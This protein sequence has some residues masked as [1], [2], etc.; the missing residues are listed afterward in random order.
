MSKSIIIMK[1]TTAFLLGLIISLVAISQAPVV[2]W[3]RVLGSGGINI[4][5]FTVK[6]I[7]NG[8]ISVWIS[9]IMGSQGMTV[10]KMTADG[11]IQWQTTYTTQYGVDPPVAYFY[12][13]DGSIV[14]LGRGNK[15]I[16]SDIYD[17]YVV[18]LDNNGNKLWENWY[19]GTQKD[20]PSSI[21]KSINGGYLIIGSTISPELTGDA[22]GN[23]DAWLIKISEAGVLEWQNDLGGTGTEGISKNYGRGKVAESSDGSIYVLTQTTSI[24]GDVTDNHG[25]QDIWLVKLN[26]GGTILWAKSLGGIGS[27]KFADL[28]ISP[29][30]ELYVLGSSTSP[31]LTIDGTAQ[32]DIYV[33][34]VSPAGIILFQKTFGS[35]ATD[36]ATQIASIGNDGSC[37]LLG[38]A[39]SATGDVQSVTGSTDI[40]IFKINQAGTILW[41]NSIDGHYIYHVDEGIFERTITGGVIQSSDGGYFMSGMSTSTTIPGYRGFQDVLVAKVSSSGVL[42]WARA[43]GGTG[44][45]I[46]K[47]L[48][49]ELS[50]NEFVVTAST[51]SNDGDVQRS[52]GGQCPW[53]IKTGPLNTIKGTLFLDRN[54]DGIKD[55]GEPPFSLAKVN[56]SKGS[57]TWTAVPFDGSFYLTADTGNYVTAPGIDLLYYTTVPL[58]H[59]SNFSTYFNTDSFSF[60]VQPI[61]GMQD[62]VLN[63]IPLTPA[64]PGFKADYE[65]TYRNV[66]TVAI[67]SAEV[68]FKMDPRSTLFSAIPSITS[69]IGDTLKW[70]VGAL[71]PGALGKITIKLQLAA[72][73]ALNNGDTLT[74]LALITP[75]MG[76]VT[77]NDDSAII[78]QIVQGSFDPND[79]AENHGGRI[80]P[81]QIAAGEYLTY[82]IRFQNLGT[83]LAFN[84]VVRDTLDNKLDW[85]TF[86]M[87]SA[88][89]PYHL[90]INESNKLVW[91]FN[92]IE[93]PYSAINEP[94][95]HGYIAFRIKPKAGLGIGANITNGASIYFDFNLPVETNIV[96]TIVG[97]P[98]TLPLHLV[99]FS[100]SYRKPDALL[101]WSTADEFNVQ[102]FII[103]R[104]TDPL[105]FAAVGTVA[106]KGGN[107]LT[108]Y[109]FNDKLASI[110]GDKFYYRLKMMDQDSKFTYS[111]IQFVQREGRAINELV[112]SPNPI[113]GRYGFAWINLQKETMA[114]IGVVDMNGNYRSLGQQRIKKGFNVVPLD[115]FGL[116]AGAYF[117]QVKTGQERLISR[118]VLVQ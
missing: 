105:H 33:A 43:Y 82:L 52:I 12:N 39:G 30:G 68:L 70:N 37:V 42:E 98:I 27:D 20:V 111:N 18:K 14:I 5:S 36:D 69:S 76:D 24:D 48:P 6:T 40:W 95:S 32:T 90:Q 28:K 59:N 72:P 56:I 106:A 44:D 91:T 79:K 75:V 116:S 97:L 22:S 53:I 86:E 31:E 58:Q 9:G 84:I 71:S 16:M 62:L 29:S 19:G 2:P 13:A 41:Q 96:S 15:D 23:T 101:S 34:R 50:P 102:K 73:P 88:S 92:D 113:K 89:H 103:E 110:S 57:G 61:P 8:I 87:V 4:P 7:D 112:I 25:G 63:V 65:L 60:A 54:N 47:G 74:S 104:G 114:E 1:K 21:I 100:A 94:G 26:S 109:Q 51:S 118:F 66:G 38:L 81:A 55:A 45:D 78:N 107:S 85:A 67:P 99:E 83:D 10:A 11:L 49:I 17:Y 64:R 3:Q 108:H 35:F 46:V 80:A 93:L 115:F 117:L 77:P